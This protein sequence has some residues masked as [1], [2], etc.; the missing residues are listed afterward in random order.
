MEYIEVSNRIWPQSPFLE[1]HLQGLGQR[2]A[3]YGPQA[4]ILL[5]Q[6]NFHGN[7]YLFLYLLPIAVLR[8]SSKVEL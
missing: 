2:M 1:V 3:N 4:S 5:L 6:I 7:T 8:H